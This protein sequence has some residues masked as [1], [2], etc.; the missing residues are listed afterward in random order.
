M[1]ITA[2]AILDDVNQ[3]IESRHYANRFTG[4]SA[5]QFRQE[6]CLLQAEM[7]SKYKI[8]TALIRAINLSMV[9]DLVA[10][11]KKGGNKQ[12][13]FRHG[14][15][16]K[17]EGADNSKITMMSLP[18]NETDPITPLSAIEFIST[19]LTLLFLQAQVN[20]ECFVEY[21]GNMRSKQPGLALQQC[22][23]AEGCESELLG[24]VNYPEINDKNKD[25]LQ[26]DGGLAWD[27]QKV[28]ALLGDNTYEKMVREMQS[29]SQRTKLSVLVT[30]TQ[31]H[32]ALGTAKGVEVPRLS[33]Y[34]FLLHDRDNDTLKIFNNGIYYDKYTLKDMLLITDKKRMATAHYQFEQRLNRNQSRL[35]DVSDKNRWILPIVDSPKKSLSV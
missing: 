35:G 1:P 17:Q 15:Q 7:A 14:E 28:N 29:L 11:V 18:R 22:L 32:Q 20:T 24:C 6:V 30:H 2:Q 21:S 33:N 9:E 34:G 23:N 19:Q 4:M 12:L 31:Q 27:K 26:P 5:E 10:S 13:F 3:Q 8:D 16:A 25:Y